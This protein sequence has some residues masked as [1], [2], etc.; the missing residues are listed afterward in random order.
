MTVFKET[1][2]IT[3]GDSVGKT[4]ALLEIAREHEEKKCIFMDFE[5]KVAKIHAA[6]FPDVDNIEFIDIL[7]WNSVEDGFAEVKSTL[8]VGDWFLIDG[9]DKAWDIIQTTYDEN[10][11]EH[12]PDMWK[13][14][15]GRHNKEF[16]DVACGRAPFHVAATAWSAPNDEINIQRERDETVKDNLLRW[17]QFGFKPGGEKRNTA[18]FDTV[19]ALRSTVNPVKF[20]VATYKDKARPYLDGG[21]KSLWF[22]FDFPLWDVYVARCQKAKDDGEIVIMPE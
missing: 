12:G 7:N 6:Y 11:K 5:N 22:E 19:L 1:I 20:Y 8:G 14:C 17:K 15:K 21:S 4:A 13:F 10:N 18:R 3:G 2:L 9:L 16:I